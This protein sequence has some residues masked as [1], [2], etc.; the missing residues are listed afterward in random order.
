MVCLGIAVGYAGILAIPLQAV[1]L[2]IAGITL[3]LV[4]FVVLAIRW[5][6]SATTR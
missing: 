4:A 1:L 3:A 6:P 5:N 2:L